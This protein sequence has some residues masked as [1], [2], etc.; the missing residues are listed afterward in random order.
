MDIEYVK[1]PQTGKAIKVGSVT[2]NKLVKQGIFNGEVSKKEN[3]IVSKETNRVRAIIKKNKMSKEQ[4][5]EERY[6]YSL[7]NSG[8][9]VI[10]KS[11]KS[12]TIKVGNIVDRLTDCSLNVYNSIKNEFENKTDFFDSNDR[13]RIKKLILEELIKNNKISDNNIEDNNELQQTE[14]IEQNDSEW[15]R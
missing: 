3:H 5:L 14:D 7:D 6:R 9:N 11:K 12:D 10:K 1:N 8:K 4:P 13:K 2:Y 15:E